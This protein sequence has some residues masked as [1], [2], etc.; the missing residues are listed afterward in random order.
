MVTVTLAEAP[1]GTVTLGRSKCAVAMDAVGDSAIGRCAHL[2]D[3]VV[4]EDVTNLRGR[5]PRARLEQERHGA[6]DVR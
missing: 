2:G 5:E 6:G 1:A 3:S 4:L